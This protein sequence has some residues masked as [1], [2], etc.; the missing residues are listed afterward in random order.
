MESPCK[1]GSSP[2]CGRIPGKG[3]W[4]HLAAASSSLSPLAINQM[5]EVVMAG[6]FLQR[7]HNE[8][9]LQL[10]WHDPTPSNN[11]SDSNLQETNTFHPRGNNS[12]VKTQIRD[13]FNT[14]NQIS[15]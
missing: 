1:G 2:I 15:N 9:S 7:L 4:Q 5:K 11:Q 10:L 13:F 6:C 14:A 8:G 3:F 12:K